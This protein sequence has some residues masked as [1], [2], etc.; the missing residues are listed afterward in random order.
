MSRSG[1]PIITVVLLLASLAPAQATQSD[2]NAA[3]REAEILRQREMDETKQ[4]FDSMANQQR[5]SLPT[6]SSNRSG[7]AERSRFYDAVPEFRAA[8]A[9]LRETVGSGPDL[10]K[11][12]KALEKLID[13]LQEYF[14]SVSAKAKRVDLSDLEGLSRKELV[15]ETL[16]VAET[17]DNNLQIARRAVQ[18]SDRD[19][20]MNIKVLQFFIE[21]Q[22]DL[23]RLR[24]LASKTPRR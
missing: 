16:T 24:Y 11:P 20:S 8:T 1:I 23:T 5:R 13:P 9:V 7:A 22:G 18:Q 19:G 14:D 21:I 15:W 12:L 10:S 2:P 6:L 4:I 3:A 17:I